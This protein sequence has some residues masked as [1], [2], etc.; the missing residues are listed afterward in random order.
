MRRL[1][2]LGTGQQLLAALVVAIVVGALGVSVP[3]LGNAAMLLASAAL[4]VCLAVLAQWLWTNRHATDWSHDFTPTGTSRGADSRV[5][6]LARTVRAAG[7][8]DADAARR[9]HA[10]VSALAAERLRDRRGLRLEAD[11]D[12]SRTALGPELAAYLV[13]N[14]A[15]RVTAARLDTHITT[16]EEL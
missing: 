3:V 15:T 1:R 8:G 6:G 13:A 16:L 4:L 9:V 5:T 11:P 14:P 2:E 12:A 10:V 7:D